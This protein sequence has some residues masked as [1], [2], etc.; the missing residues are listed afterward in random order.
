MPLVA[1]DPSRRISD[2]QVDRAIG[3]SEG[4]RLQAEQQCDHDLLVRCIT[5]SSEDKSPVV[6][7]FDMM[8]E[9]TV[10]CAGDRDFVDPF[11]GDAW[12][13]WPTEEVDTAIAGQ[14]NATTFDLTKV[15]ISVGTDS[16]YLDT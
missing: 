3:H 7:I 9:T 16:G 5:D 14:D 6:D 13:T 8:S 2:L 15:E 12:A 4:E 10:G 1:S 11:A